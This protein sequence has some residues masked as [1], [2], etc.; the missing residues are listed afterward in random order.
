MKKHQVKL[1]GI[2]AKALPGQSQASNIN[3][4]VSGEDAILAGTNEIEGKEVDPEKEYMIPNRLIMPVDH[5]KRIKRAFKSNGKNG[6]IEYCEKFLKRGDS[7]ELEEAIN[8]V[9]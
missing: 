8:M 1:I 9:F 2:I 5:I 3:S 6:I 7:T 4:I